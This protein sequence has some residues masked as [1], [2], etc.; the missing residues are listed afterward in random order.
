VP[1]L[2]TSWKVHAPDGYS[3]VDP[4]TT[5]ETGRI[6]TAPALAGILAR[7][8]AGILDSLP[9]GRFEFKYAN[10]ERSV[11]PLSAPRGETWYQSVDEMLFAGEPATAQGSIHAV[12]PGQAR[13]VPNAGQANNAHFKLMGFSD[14][15]SAVKSGVLPVKLELPA[16]GRVFSFRGHERPETLTLRYSSWERQMTKAC[17]WL[18]AGLAGFCCC[19]RQRPCWRTFLMVLVLTCVPLALLPTWLPMANALLAGWLIGLGVWLLRR[20][21]Q[22]VER[23]GSRQQEAGRVLG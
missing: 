4:E 12:L 16:T 23:T 19:G 20:L 18:L 10:A 6:G 7:P 11:P 22:W 1:V 9:M 14:T 17:F 8:F 13:A 15:A 2:T 3:Y 5:L 21:A